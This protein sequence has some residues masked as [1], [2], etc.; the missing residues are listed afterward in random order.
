MTKEAVKTAGGGILEKDKKVIHIQMFGSFSMSNDFYNFVPSGR[1]RQMSR[2]LSYIIANKDTDISKE[3]LI[4]IL[5][6]EEELNNPGGALRNLVYRCRTELQKFFPEDKEMECILYNSSTYRWNEEVVCDIDIFEFEKMMSQADKESD[7][8]LRFVYLKKAYDIYK[9]DF[10]PME[11]EEEW[12]L[13]RSVYYKNLYTRCVLELCQYYQKKGQYDQVIALSSASSLADILDERIHREKIQAY[14]N[15]GSAQQALEYYY[16]ISDLFSQKFGVQ[17]SESMHD[18]YKEIT[19]R[20]ANH[21]VDINKLE[22]NLKNDTKKGTFYC[23]FDVFRNIYQINLRSSRRSQRMRF[24]ILF[25]LED[26]R[27]PEMSTNYLKEDMEIMHEVLGNYLRSNDVYTQS[28]PTQL[29]L[30]L[31]VVNEKGRDVAVNRVKEKFEDKHKHKEVR[32]HI[33]YREIH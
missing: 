15:K 12:V 18:I 13:F 19:C 28:S 9:G 26:T 11:A 1:S 2:L 32:L 16:A 3:K 5:W 10:L 33:E 24:L 14:L 25:T 4:E 17:L 29:S 23:N 31:T 30:I 8:D 27:C 22:K 20:L 7:K 6:P 21:P